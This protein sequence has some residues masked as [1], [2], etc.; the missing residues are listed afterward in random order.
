MI[1]LYGFLKLAAVIA[2]GVSAAFGSYFLKK[3]SAVLSA[4]PS[5][6]AKAESGAAN[7]AVA[8]SGVAGSD[9]V[10]TTTQSGLVG[11]IVRLLT[12]PSFY[13]GGFLYVLASLLSIYLLKVLPYSI[14]VPLGG[15]TY[16]WTLIISARLLHER[17]T[18]RKF[19][20]VVVILLG[21]F[22]IATS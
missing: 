17:I 20:G 18:V 2:S 21:V 19:A 10:Q 22:L 7:G 12:C 8:G 5:T 3:A 9:M 15:L 4:S 6:Q 16:I 11:V 13:L 14:V 1:N